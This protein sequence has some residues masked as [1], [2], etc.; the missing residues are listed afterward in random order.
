M[1]EFKSRLANHVEHVKT[2]GAHCATEETTKQALILP[3]L[4]ILGFSPFDP[5]KVRAEYCADFP[6]VKSSER[7][8]YALF[9][10]NQPVMF[11]EAKAYA[12]N[13][14]NHSPQL[15]RYF[16][17]TPGVKIA[18][19]TNGKEWRFFT[20][21]KHQ[22]MMDDTPFLVV[23]LLALADDAADQLSRFRYDQFQPDSLRTFAESRMYLAAFRT[24]IET[25]LREVDAEF[26]RFIA[27]RANLEGKLTAKFLESITPL[28][29]QAVAEAVG[30][31][32]VSGLSAQPAPAPAPEPSMPASTGSD[33]TDEINPDNPRI[34]TTAAEKRLLE[35]VQDMLGGAASP[36]EIVGKDTESYYAILYKGKNNRW[37]LRYNGDRARPQ[38]SMPR[39]LTPEDDARLK[40]IGMERGSGNH[41]LLDKP[42]HI[43][44]LSW[45]LFDAL[46]YCKDDENFKMKKDSNV[47]A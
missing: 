14:T 31:M 45:L 19:I 8:D 6:G 27:L 37:L 30:G 42:E 32:V 24:A 2:A 10:D 36:D 21:L 20:D 28:V 38:I 26:V 22:N 4:D 41:I 12:Q 1:L 44:R 25:S 46:D 35:I 29:K 39:D 15:S 3:L 5:L 34:I 23:Q 43:M 18:A 7:V 47:A 11:V 13:L 40:H 16:N 9:S 17:A 33:K